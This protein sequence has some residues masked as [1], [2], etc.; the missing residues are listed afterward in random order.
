MAQAHIEI[1]LE[2]MQAIRLNGLQK[3]WRYGELTT[4][5]S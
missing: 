3:L 4:K 2:L 1:F 5:D